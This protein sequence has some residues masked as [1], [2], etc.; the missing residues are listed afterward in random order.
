M[1]M[2]LNNVSILREGAKKPFPT[3]WGA[4]F[5]CL[6]THVAKLSQLHQKHYAQ[7]LAENGKLLGLNPNHKPLYCFKS[8]KKKICTP[9]CA[10]FQ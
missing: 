8:L 10:R 3:Y 6:S 9:T 7:T 2:Q 1:P 5:N 4:T